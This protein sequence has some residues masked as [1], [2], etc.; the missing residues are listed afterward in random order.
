MAESVALE[1]QGDVHPARWELL[2]EELGLTQRDVYRTQTPLDLADLMQIASISLPNLFDPPIVPAVPSVFSNVTDA[3]TLFTSLRERDV[4]VH[5]PYESFD[6]TVARFVDEAAEDP[7]VLA[8]KQTMYR[9][10]PDSPILAS[11]IDAAGRGKQVAVLVELTARFDEANNIEGRGVGEASLREPRP[12][13]PPRSASWCGRSRRRD[14]VRPHRDGEL[15]LADGPALHGL[16]PLHRG[17]R[18]LRRPRAHLQLPDGLCGGPRDEPP[19]DRSREPPQRARA[20]G[21][22]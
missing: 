1:M 10:S 8:I 15:Q 17:P 11:L 6:A 2:L 16:W 19:V 14:D 18:H 21:A 7:A 4:L 22:P 3:A 9:T 5:H 12:E 20:A 13:D